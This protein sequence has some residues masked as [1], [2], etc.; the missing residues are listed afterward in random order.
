[1]SR[2]L[3]LLAVLALLIGLAVCAVA[4][5]GLFQPVASTTSPELMLA[6]EDN[7][8]QAA[9]TYFAITLPPAPA[10]D[11]YHVARKQ[12]DYWLRF[13]ATPDALRGLLADSPVL[14]CDDLDLLDGL[15]PDFAFDELLSLPE[16]NALAWWT[17]DSAGTLV[18]SDCVGDDLTAYKMLADSANP[19]LWIVY[20]E[21]TRP[22][23]T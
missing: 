12:D 7:G 5:L 6:T 16:Q 14:A 18:G 19:D 3:L 13:L 1:M 11:Q 10:T 2:L 17:P 15:R 9:E 21:I 22:Q 23:V 8:R 20:M 4:S